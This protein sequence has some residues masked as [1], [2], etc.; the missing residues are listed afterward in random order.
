MTYLGGFVPP[1]QGFGQPV[2]NLGFNRWGN[3]GM[4]YQTMNG[5]QNIDYSG[6]WNSNYHDQLLRNNIDI[7]YQRYD[8]NFSGQL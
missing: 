1:T 5:Y 3:S 4:N 7:V 6:G 2:I 8:M